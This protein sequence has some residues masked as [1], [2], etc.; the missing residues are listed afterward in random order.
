MSNPHR[1]GRPHQ[2]GASALETGR[3]G[4]AWM[5][6]AV[7]I[8]SLIWFA[9]SARTAAHDPGRPYSAELASSPA[10]GMSGTVLRL[11]PGH[12]PIGVPLPPGHPPVDADAAP[13]PMRRLPAWHPPIDERAGETAKLPPGFVTGI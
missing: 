1:A 10:C 3:P 6:G 8:A 13:L 9:T 2:P 11:P 7:T 12:P 4:A 5:I